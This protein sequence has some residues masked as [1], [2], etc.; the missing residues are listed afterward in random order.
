[1]ALAPSVWVSFDSCL[2]APYHVIQQTFASF[3]PLLNKRQPFCSINIINVKVYSP[4]YSPLNS[5]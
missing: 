4:I 5:F 2:I 1:M 3:E